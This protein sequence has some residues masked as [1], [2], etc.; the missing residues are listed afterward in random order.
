LKDKALRI[1]LLS[2]W[3]ALLAVDAHASERP[4][5]DEN[6]SD[7]E[8][9]EAL[10]NEM[11]IEEKTGQLRYDAPG[12]ERLG[13]LPY[14]WWN[15]ALHGV[16]ANGRATVFPQPI[17]LAATFDEDLVERIAIAIS[18]EARAK[19]NVAQ[20]L[21]NY[22]RYAG[23][24][25]WS[26]NINIFRD[27]RWGR[28]ME[29]YGED[30]FLQARLGAAFV[31][32]LQGDNPNRLKVAACAKHF[33]VHSGPEALRHEFDVTAPRR[34]LY[35]TYLPAFEALVGEG[36]E[37]VMCAYN[38][39]D[40]VPACGSEFLLQDVL[41]DQ[42]GFKG[43][44]VSDCWAINDFHDRHEVSPGAVES[45]AWALKAGTDLNCG[46]A[47]ANGLP[48]A[49]EKGLVSEGDID[50]A[51]RRLLRTKLKLGLF[52]ADTEWDALG[53][54]VVESEQHVRLAREAAQKSIVLLKNNGILP[55]KKDLRSLYVVGPH[56]NDNDI[57]LGNYNGFSS[58]TVSVLEGI[59]G[60]VSAGTS[61][62][63][64]YGQLPFSDNINPID[65]VTGGAHTADATI[66]VVGSSGLIEGEEG[67]ALA[68]PTKGDRI[69]LNLPKP[70]LDFVKR[71]RKA[72]DKPLIIVVTGGSPV[73]MPELHELADAILF[74]WYPGQ[75]GGAAVA[76]ILFGD[77]SPS[78]RLPITFPVS[79]EQL[80]P[81]EDYS[82]R[83]R[84]YKYMMHE[85]LYPFGFGLSFSRFEY[86]N[87]ELSARELY[88]GETISADVTVRN[89]GDVQ[90]DEVVQLYLTVE[91][92]DFEVPLASLVGF[93]RVALD[94]GESVVVNF[95]ISAQ[96]VR[97]FDAGGQ[98]QFVPG[99]YTV[100]VGGISPG[101]RGED[102]TG[103]RLEQAVFKFR[104]APD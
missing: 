29:T 45:A 104:A 10:I 8:R 74:I 100:R 24:T 16:A 71:L 23:I 81:Y 68:S 75:Q 73:T 103:S 59:I 7:A 48:E 72:N 32:G 19:F 87:L 64:S 18:D 31:R 101:K 13:V 86:S 65:W 37:C 53:D 63:Y 84:T 20:S 22:G 96:Q 52:D 98:P 94:A 88:A 93:R 102:L 50:T 39:V 97:V 76:D 12:I 55:L 15:E 44:V 36:V 54:E 28:G 61:V 66:I 47:F 80:P 79:V 27:P 60:A 57:L 5:R 46:S 9:I 83:G 1:V 38:R 43:H 91:D 41:R 90:S 62:N 33:A 40:G 51:L 69:D 92:A 11:T 42:W 49:V 95:A 82:M 67:A 78:G 77:V 85:P 89:V 35:E 34:D 14:T 6:R 4:W 30:P 2:I 26:P 56:A 17:G 21:G 70:Q 3:I 99:T 25:F 58:A